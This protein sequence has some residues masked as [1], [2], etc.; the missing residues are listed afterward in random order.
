MIARNNYGI[1]IKYP[2][3]GRV[4]TRL[5]RQLGEG[6]AAEVCR[7]VAEQVLRNTAPR[8]NLYHRTIFIDPPDREADFRDWLP[9]ERF[10]GQLGNDLGER[11]DNAIIQLLSTGAEKAVITGADI[12]ELSR[13]IVVQ[14]FESLDH[15]DVVIGPA[16]DGGYYLIGTKTPA[17]ELFYDVPWSTQYVFALTIQALARSGK[18]YRLLPVLSDLDTAEDLDTIKK[19]NFLMNLRNNHFHGM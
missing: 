11:M 2:D 19:R 15:V 7:C 3:P 6:R 16:A 13:D 5:A 14:A 9:E 8:E 18:S 17:P 12:P 1:M 10:T 4:K